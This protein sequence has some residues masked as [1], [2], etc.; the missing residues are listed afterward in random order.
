MAQI[1]TDKAAPFDAINKI[2]NELIFS[3]HDMARLST[4]PEWSVRTA[5]AE[6][7]HRAQYLRVHDI[8]Y[9][10]GGDDDPIAPRVRTAI[11]EMERTCRG[12]ID[13]KGTLFSIINAHPRRG[14]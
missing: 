7:K 13:S 8:Y 5:E 10:T 14:S 11:A 1:G 6:E 2:T 4:V 12:I 9:G 3:A